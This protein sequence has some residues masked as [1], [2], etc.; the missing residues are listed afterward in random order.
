MS[1]YGAEDFIQLEEYT[2][3]DALQAIEDAE[4]VVRIVSKV[5]ER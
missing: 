3:E 2:A 1:F 4:F 5:F